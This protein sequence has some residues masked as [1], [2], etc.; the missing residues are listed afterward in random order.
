[1]NFDFSDD[2][3]LLRDQAR[4]FLAEKC[5]PKAV[6]AVLEGEAGYDRALWKAI[7]EMGWLG[8][9]IPENCGG[10]G[11]GYLELCV[12]AEELGRALAPVPFSSTVYLFAEALLAAG[13]EQQKSR[14]LPRVADGTLIGTFARAEGPG[15]VTPKSTRV[16]FRSGKLSGIKTAVVDGIDADFAV[17]LA[18]T[19]DEP[20]ER[21]LSL[22]LVDL[23]AAGVM[24]KAQ[25][26]ID[27]S[28]KHA[29]ITFDAAPA[30]A[31]GTPGEGWAVASRVLDHAA[32]MMA[33]EQVGAADACLVMARDYALN[34]YAFGR[35][36]ASYQA[37]KHKLADMYVNNELAR[38]NA[39]YG[40]WALST[41]APELPL[42]AAAARVCATQA[43]DYAAKENIQTHGGVGFTWEFDC[44][45][46]Y[47]RSRELALSL[48]P[49]R[50]WKDRLVSALER[51]N[52]A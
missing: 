26:S 20:G 14:L 43:F 4:K 32:V 31:L 11:L 24:R 36:I 3:K 48:G 5:P 6:R 33:F 47:K 42:A 38:S 29:Q 21:G 10:L 23:N 39:Y 37:I 30:E 12:V 35:P 27:P 7:A 13:S 16:S 52:A 51:A 45:L 22:A 49:Q 15:A 18:R 9:A 2:Q 17:V 50:L 41:G 44:H 19:S 28:R 34:R 1:M 40:A 8:T 25:D 46:Y